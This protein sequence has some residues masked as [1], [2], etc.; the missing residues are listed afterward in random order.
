MRLGINYINKL[1]FLAAYHKLVSTHSKQTRSRIAFQTAGLVPFNPQPVLSKL[2]IQLRTP[3]PPASRGSESSAFYPHTPVNIDELLKQASSSKTFLKQHSNSPPSPS[4]AA[5]NQ[6][7]K[8]CQIAMQNGILEEENKQLHAANATQRQKRARVN[9]WI[10]QDN[11]LSVQ[12]ALELEETH[13]QFF[14]PRTGLRDAP[15]QATQAPV[16]R[17]LPKCGNCSEIGHKKNVCPRRD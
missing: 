4:Q 9:R 15:V 3:T 8:G 11:G 12:E 14:Q 7:I 16:T 17:R 10:A 5:L 1:D 6:L 2:N 13:N